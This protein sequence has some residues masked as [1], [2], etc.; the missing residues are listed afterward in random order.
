MGIAPDD[1]ELVGVCCDHHN[2]LLS[3]YLK[4]SKNFKKIL[5]KYVRL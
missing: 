5:A 4:I 2:N 3:Q 1:R